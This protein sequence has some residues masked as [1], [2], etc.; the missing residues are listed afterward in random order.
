MPPFVIALL[1]L[2]LYQIVGSAINFPD[3]NQDD[4]VALGQIASRQDIGL[5]VDCCLGSFVVPFLERA[6]LASGEMDAEGNVR[7]K[8]EPFDFRVKGVTSVS[9]DTDKVCSTGIMHCQRLTVT[10]IFDWDPL[11]NS[12]MHSP[13]RFLWLHV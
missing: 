12:G 1:N 10:N 6:G 4:I 3:G 2:S 7:Y 11:L 5:H 9:C 8:L 13:S